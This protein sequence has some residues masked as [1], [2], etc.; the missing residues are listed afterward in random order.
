MNT[1]IQHSWGH[2]PL[3]L[4]A[5]AALSFADPP[6]D[7]GVKYADDPTGDKRPDIYRMWAAS[8][9]KEMARLTRRDGTVWWMCPEAHGDFIGPIMSEWV[10]PRVHR[11]IWYETFAQY[12]QKKL[13]E[14][15]RFIFC[16]QKNPRYDPRPLTFNPDAIRIPSD[17]QEKYNDKRANPAGRVPGQVWKIRRLQGTSTDHVDWHPAQLPPEILTRI[18]RGWS[19]PGDTVLDAFAG[20]GNMGLACKRLDRRFIGVDQSPTYCQKIRER[21]ADEQ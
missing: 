8:V 15:Y 13:T 20:S 2:T 4:P 16:H 17:R 18:V 3:Y 19:N 11:V 5:L 10:G 14:D 7:I 1:V 9:I 21:L 12:Q 6:Y